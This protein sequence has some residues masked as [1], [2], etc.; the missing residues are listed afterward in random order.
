MSDSVFIDGYEICDETPPYVIAEISANHNGS[1][2]VAKELIKR[3]KRAGANAVKLQTYTADTLT[4]KSNKDDFMID[5]G[6]WKGRT[7]Y[8]LYESAYT[9]WE[10]HSELFQVAKSLGITL[11]SSPFDKTAVDFLDELGAPAFKIASFEAI[12]L[13]L[14]KYAASKNKPLIISTGMCNPREIAEVVDTVKGAGCAQFAL[15]HCVSA[16]P[17]KPSDYNL[18]TISHLKNIYRLQVGLSDHTTSNVTSISAIGFG[19]QIIE[20]HF[21][22]NK[23]GGGP[24]DSFSIEE[25]E[26]ASLTSDVKTAWQ[27][28]GKV[29]E[30]TTSSEQK[31]LRFRRSV[32]FMNSL[33]VGET[34]KEEDVRIIRPGYGVPPK[35]INDIIGKKVKNNV[36]KHQKVSFDDFEE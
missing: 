20:K 26:L 35:Y 9:P 4:V 29:K 24:D 1:I 11:F 19:A 21:T 17:A 25:H 31:S 23:E 18:Q 3:A 8:E 2:E 15:L 22:L 28:K 32:Y 7:L 34:I 13:P 36:E 33:T 12:D 27:A 30:G 5:D 14:V 10:W 16:Y 6:L